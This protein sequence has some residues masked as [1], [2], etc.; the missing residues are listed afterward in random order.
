MENS[1]KVLP[2]LVFGQQRIFVT[3]AGNARSHGPGAYRV[4]HDGDFALERR[5]EQVDV[6]CR[7]GQLVG[8]EQ[9]R[10]EPPDI[11]RSPILPVG[12]PCRLVVELAEEV[13]GIVVRHFRHI[14]RIYDLHFPDVEIGIGL[15]VFGQIDGRRIAGHKFCLHVIL[16][17]DRRGLDR[18]AVCLAPV[19]KLVGQ[20]IAFPGHDLEFATR[21]GLR[22]QRGQPQQEC[23]AS[24][25]GH[26][27]EN[28]SPAD[29]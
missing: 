5:I 17:G 26:S 2:S 8:I 27:G 12:E 3:E 11:G 4:V 7:L 13:V 1:A 21:S 10:V 28:G 22:R 20:V 6:G 23:P 9:D 24:Q 25:A 19:R 16:V 15:I 18:H 29:C 14:D